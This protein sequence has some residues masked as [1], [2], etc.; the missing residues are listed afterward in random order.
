MS[1]RPCP[2]T[3][4]SIARAIRAAGPLRVVEVLADGTIRILP[5]G[6]RPKEVAK[7]LEV[8]L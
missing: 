2:V 6:E 7:P 4:A 8:R 3:Q 1:R 5:E